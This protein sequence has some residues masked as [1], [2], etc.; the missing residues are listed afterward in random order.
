MYYLSIIFLLLYALNVIDSKLE[1]AKLEGS[2]LD[3]FE[4][5][6]VRSWTDSKLDRLEFGGS[7]LEVT[8]LEDSKLESAKVDVMVKI[9]Y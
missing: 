8:E 6:Q 9:H 5:K 7:N 4:N 2:N 3:R 1:G